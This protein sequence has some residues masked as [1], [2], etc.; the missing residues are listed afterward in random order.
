MTMERL[1]QFASEFARR[2]TDKALR[3][4]MKEEG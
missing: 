1:F 3:E 4:T 2:T